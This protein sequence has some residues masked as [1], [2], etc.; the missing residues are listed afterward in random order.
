MIKKTLKYIRLVLFRNYR[1]KIIA[2][3]LSK[4]ILKLSETKK[5]LKILDYG[6]G[7]QPEVIFL[8]LKNLQKNS[9]K[10]WLINCC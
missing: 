7:M 4:E 3:I 1:E 6:S 10:N 9:N 8:L 5:T 2:N